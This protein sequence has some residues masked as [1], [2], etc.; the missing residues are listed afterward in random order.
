MPELYN[1]EKR[2]KAITSTR[3]KNISTRN[4]LGVVEERE[5]KRLSLV[6]VPAS[7]RERE[8]VEENS[9]V[10]IRVREPTEMGEDIF[11]WQMEKREGVTFLSTLIFPLWKA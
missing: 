5:R 6:L 10:Q 2:H 1:S 9:R 11:A 3:V 7:C 4:K 8:R